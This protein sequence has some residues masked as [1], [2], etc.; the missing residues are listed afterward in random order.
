[1]TKY[2]LCFTTR[3]LFQLLEIILAAP[4]TRR[5]KLVDITSCQSVCILRASLSLPART[6]SALA[7]G[8]SRRHFLALFF[9]FKQNFTDV[10]YSC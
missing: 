4:H 2:V 10:P 3:A 5:L 8:L 6:G 9:F 1:M 7:A